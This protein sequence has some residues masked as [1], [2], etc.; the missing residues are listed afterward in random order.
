VAEVLVQEANPT[1]SEEEGP[2]PFSN[3]S[4]HKQYDELFKQQPL[5]LKQI[6][7]KPDRS[8]QAEEP[9]SKKV[10]FSDVYAIPRKPLF[11]NREYNEKDRAYIGWMTF[12]HG[13][14]LLAPFTF[15]WTNL[16]LFAFMYFITGCLGITL[17]FH[18]CVTT[19]AACVHA[20]CCSFH[21]ML[22][23]ALY[24]RA[25]IVMFMLVC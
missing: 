5:P 16:G 8:A 15:S 18:R 6:V 1:S 17:S 25:G 3:L 20:A 24:M 2:I 11:T 14:A 22:L 4:Y 9:G 12:V 13:L 21:V 19:A 23:L 7:P 10:P